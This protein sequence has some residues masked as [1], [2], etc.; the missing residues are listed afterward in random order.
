MEEVCPPAHIVDEMENLAGRDYEGYEKYQRGWMAELSKVGLAIP[1]WPEKYGGAGLSLKHLIIVAE[2]MARANAPK[3]WLYVISLIHLPATLMA[4]G[5]ESQK[6]RYLPGVAKGV[7]WCQGFSEP[8]A[9]SDL[10]S[11]RTKAERIGNEYVI[12]GQKVWSSLSMHAEYCI[13]LA[14]TNSSVRK[15][16]GISYFVMNMKAPGVEV[17]PI[18]QSTGRAEFS[19]LFLKDVRIPV[20]DRIGEENQGWEVAQTTLTSERGVIALDEAERFRY[21]VERFYR[22]ALQEGAGGW[23]DDDQLRR[24]FMRFLSRLQAVRGLIRELLEHNDRDPSAPT[25]TPSVIKVAETTLE[26]HFYEF[27][28]RIKGPQAQYLEP[29]PAQRAGIAGNP[30]HGFVGSYGRTIA[31]GTNEIQLNI[32]SERGLGM[33]RG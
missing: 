28:T 20:E 8:G 15:H 17:R 26:Q 4:W 11:L 33:P 13:L 1:H 24:E 7:I 12:N 21:R 10:A 19:E 32:I 16:V 9:G 22:K 31:G 18:R 25:I 5:T 14:R 23:L 30:M 2:E 3:L 6:A 29:A 27:Q